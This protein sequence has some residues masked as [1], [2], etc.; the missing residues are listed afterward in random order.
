L[1][2]S[3]HWRFPDYPLLDVE[4][5]IVFLWTSRHRQNSPAANLKNSQSVMVNKNIFDSIEIV[6]MAARSN[7]WVYGRSLAGV[8]GSNPVERMDVCV[9]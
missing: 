4:A 7:A 9:L 3:F 1:T 2:V 5:L 6:A 8:A